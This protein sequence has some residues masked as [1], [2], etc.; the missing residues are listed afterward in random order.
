MGAITG[1]AR[2]QCARAE[3]DIGARTRWSNGAD[4]LLSTGALDPG[5]AGYRTHTI[6]QRLRGRM[7]GPSLT[8]ARIRGAPAYVW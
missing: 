5:R 6:Y 1:P 8:F 3:Q 2:V 4:I 7:A